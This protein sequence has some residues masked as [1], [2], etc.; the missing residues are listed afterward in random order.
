MAGNTC[1][2]DDD[3]FEALTAD[4]SLESSLSLSACDRCGVFRFL[5]SNFDVLIEEKKKQTPL[6]FDNLVLPLRKLITIKSKDRAK[7]LSKLTSV[8]KKYKA[9]KARRWIGK[10]KRG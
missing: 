8:Y 2:P 6:I 5:V 4:S 1:F 10:C 9:R 7:L 3:S